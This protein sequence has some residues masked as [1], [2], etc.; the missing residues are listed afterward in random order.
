MKVDLVGEILARFAGHL[1]N[2]GSSKA[3]SWEEQPTLVDLVQQIKETLAPV[4]PTAAFR[5]R[6]EQ[7]LLIPL[8]PPVLIE[9]TAPAARFLTTHK[10][11]LLGTAAVGS[12]A[13]VLSILG[14]V[15]LMIRRRVAARPA[16]QGSSGMA[17]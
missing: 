9:E 11:I 13:S 6:L 4:E 10:N 16:P 3:M 15:F 2:P 1:P 5:Q 17:L 7:E 14:L 8:R 12:V